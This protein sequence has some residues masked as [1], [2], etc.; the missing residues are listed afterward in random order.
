MPEPLSWS[1][2]QDQQLLQM[3]ADGACWDNIAAALGVSRWSAVERGRKIG[4]CKTA[5]TMNAPITSPQCDP[6]REPLPAGHSTS[7]GALVADT[8][9][10]GQSYP[11][12]PLPFG[13]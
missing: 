4:A 11:W 8:S 1:L 13:D 10:H 6:T 5:R 9:L 12:P 2:P 3:R 7:W